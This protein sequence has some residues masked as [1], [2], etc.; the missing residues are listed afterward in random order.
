MIVLGLPGTLAC[1]SWCCYQW[2]LLRRRSCKR[3]LG[4]RISRLPIPWPHS[5]AST[6]QSTSLADAHDSLGINRVFCVCGCFCLKCLRAE[7]RKETVP[8]WTRCILGTFVFCDLRFVEH[9][10]QLKHLKTT[11]VVLPGV[12]SQ[13]VDIGIHCNRIHSTIMIIL[14]L[15]VVVSFALLLWLLLLVLLSLL[16]L[17][18]LLLL[19]LWLF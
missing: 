19:L 15:V 17:V 9:L 13:W 18:L 1:K 8:H 2:V 12:Y 11:Q 3:L 16:L 7:I 4:R 14:L 6:Q 10:E 5:L